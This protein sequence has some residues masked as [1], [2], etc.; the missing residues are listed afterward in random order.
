[1]TLACVSS[2]LFFG[3]GVREIKIGDEKSHFSGGE[4]DTLPYFYKGR[5]YSG[6]LFDNHPNGKRGLEGHYRKGF[7][8]R[9][10]IWDEEGFRRVEIPFSN[11]RRH[12][13]QIIYNTD[14]STQLEIAW[15]E[16]S[17]ISRNGTEFDYFD[18]DPGYYE[19]FE[20]SRAGGLKQRETPWVNGKMHGKEIEYYRNGSK[21]LETSYENG[22]KHGTE[23]FYYGNSGSKQRETPWVNGKKHG[24]EIT[25]WHSG[26]KRN[27]RNETI[28]ENGK[29]VSSKN[30][31]I[32]SSHIDPALEIKFR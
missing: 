8:N 11:G 22:K 28:Y 1:M 25:Y 4:M 24:T 16:D 31:P 32:K 21:V 5:P 13:T 14:G 20:Y 12:G 17:E 23:I 27:K 10:T 6:V 26:N 18:S 29:K 3:C 2:F 19:G 7:L 9:M 15:E 30:F